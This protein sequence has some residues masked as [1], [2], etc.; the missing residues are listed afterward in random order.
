MPVVFI[1]STILLV[2][3]G[4]LMWLEWRGVRTTLELPFK[5]D[6]KRETAFLAQYGQSVATPVAAWLVWCSD[7][8]K[9]KIPLAIILPV[10]IASLTTTAIKRVCG[11][12]RPRHENAGKFTG[13]SLKHANHRES[14][15]SSH[16]ACAMALTWALI[17]WYPQAMVVFWVLAVITAGLRYVMDAHFPS[18]VLAGSA[19]G[20][21]VAEGVMRWLLPILDIPVPGRA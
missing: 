1:V 2:M 16:S 8:P 13:F 7:P 6:I 18:D 15:P 12:I 17:P 10:L 4:L 5:G 19:A 11:R 20:L 3:A 9:W 21:M 14:F